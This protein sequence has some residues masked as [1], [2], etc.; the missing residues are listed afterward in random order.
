M[1]RYA[2]QMALPEVGPAGQDRLGQSHVLVIGAGGLGAPVLQYLAG[3]GVGTIT[4]LD[5]DV[6]EESNLHRQPLFSMADLGRAKVTV[7]GEQLLA[8]NPELMLHLHRLALTAENVAQLLEPVDLVVDAADSFATSYILSDACLDLGLPLISASVLG[9]RGYVGGF[10]GGA[11]SLRALFPELPDSAA[12]CASAG[13]MGP[14]VGVIG[15]LQAQLALKTLLQHS[16]SPL[17]RL[18]Q[19]EMAD[20]TLSSFCFEGAPEPGQPLRFTAP[21]LIGPQDQVIDLRPVEEAPKPATA[22]ARRILPE[23][24]TSARLSPDHPVVL[25]CRSGVRAWRVARDLQ[26]QDFDRIEILALGTRGD[27]A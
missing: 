22:N 17:G 8:A 1:S 11:P 16:P 2:R 3:A 23:D 13:V 20:L 6:I 19:I 27:S 14:V 12:S 25:C 26:A 24:V 15:S 9:Q 10:C 18:M 5:P 7:A 4:L 21:A